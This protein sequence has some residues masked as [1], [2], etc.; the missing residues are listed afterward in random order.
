MT[1][2]KLREHQIEALPKLETGSILVGG[3]GSGKTLTSLAYFYTV[4]CDGTLDFD[5]P[6]KKAVDLYVITTAKKRDSLDWEHEA[7]HFSIS[8]DPEASVLGIKMTVDS[9]NNV[10]KYVDVKNAF[11]I[12][13]EQ[14]VV[15]SGKWAKSFIKI[16]KENDWILLSATPGDTWMDYVAVFVAN[17]Y[18]KNRTAFIREHVVYNSY[19]NFPLVERY[20]GEA[21]LKRL[22]NKIL[23]KMDFERETIPHNITVH[24]PFD[25]E[26]YDKV[27][28]ERWNIFDDEPLRNGSAAG[29]AMR[30]VVN[31]H[32]DRIVAVEHF[33]RKHK[34]LIV[35]YNFDYELEALREIS[36]DGYE[37]AEYNGHKHQAIPDSDRWI[38]L[39]QYTSGAE[40]WN[41]IETNAIMFYSLNYSY[42]TTIQAAG[43]IDR[44]NTP[45][46]NLYYYFVKS[47]S[48]I[49]DGVF[50]SLINKE[51]FNERDFLT[52]NNLDFLSQ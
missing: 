17:G 52:K 49:D 20:L 4:V 43:R 50:R 1:K 40:A 39:V 12:F 8:K 27:T 13:D 32:P 44:M 35:F 18:Y 2:I 7:A 38:Y 9:W 10:H 24:V 29:Y 3:V 28:K 19:T 47:D 41:C 36:I 25:N 42:R 6:P 30:R 34:R 15:G 22:R 45:F 16:S 48:S 21:K 51:D 11:F 14:R 5:K 46:R 33:A 26:M 31:S 23:V 37:I